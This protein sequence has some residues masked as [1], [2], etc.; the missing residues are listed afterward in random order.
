MEQKHGEHRNRFNRK[1]GFG[2]GW[3]HVLVVGGVAIQCYLTFGLT[4]TI[5]YFILAGAAGLISLLL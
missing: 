4:V 1:N 2:L 3:E 5:A